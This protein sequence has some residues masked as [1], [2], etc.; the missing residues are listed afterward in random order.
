MAAF[1]NDKAPYALLVTLNLE[2]LY[3]AIHRLPRHLHEQDVRNRQLVREQFHVV[4]RIPSS[5][6]LLLGPVLR[7]S[8]L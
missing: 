2:L 6:C 7:G 8:R 5:H 1:A 3:V 4:N